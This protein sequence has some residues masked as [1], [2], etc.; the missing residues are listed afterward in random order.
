MNAAHCS[1][2]EGLKELILLFIHL[3]NTSQ[4]ISW[5]LTNL[6]THSS[7]SCIRAGLS[8][9]STLGV[10]YGSTDIADHSRNFLHL[11][12]HFAAVDADRGAAALLK[13]AAALD[14]HAV[15][16]QEAAIRQLHI[17]DGTRPLAAARSQPQQ[18]HQST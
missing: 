16:P 10:T 7:Q 2:S 15:P 17:I 1:L 13:H 18:M 14:L 5:W 6:K 12:G 4:A 8:V 9:Q 3:L 11:G